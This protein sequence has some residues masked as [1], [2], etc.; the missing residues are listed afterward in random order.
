[1][2]LLLVERAEVT[3]DQVTLSDRRAHHLRTVLGVT[4]GSQVRTG[5]IGGSLGTA[6]VISRHCR[7]SSRRR[8]RSVSNAS[9]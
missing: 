1:V 6:R 7:G 5:M 9:R 2:N 3:G 8:P 4:P